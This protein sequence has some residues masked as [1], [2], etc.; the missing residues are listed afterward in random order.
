MHAEGRTGQGAAGL[1]WRRCARLAQAEDVTLAK[2]PRDQ[3]RPTHAELKEMSP[4]LHGK[5]E[6][7]AL[8]R[9]SPLTTGLN[10]AAV[11]A[12]VADERTKIESCAEHRTA[13]GSIVNPRTPPPQGLG[14]K[15]GP[16]RPGDTLWP[17]AE[18]GGAKAGR[19]AGTQQACSRRSRCGSSAACGATRQARPGSAG[20]ATALGGT[21]RVDAARRTFQSRMKMDVVGVVEFCCSGSSSAFSLERDSAFS[22]AQIRR[23]C[24][25]AADVLRAGGATG[26]SERDAHPPPLALIPPHVLDSSGVQKS[27]PTGGKYTASLAVLEFFP[28]RGLLVGGRRVPTARAHS[29]IRCASR[30]PRPT[31]ASTRADDR[32]TRSGHQR[33]TSRRDGG[34]V[35]TCRIRIQCIQNEAQ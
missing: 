31:R 27:L 28:G 17:S 5:S 6:P 16:G 10:Q 2:L 1:S 20:C 30:L 19:A 33:V 26:R 25:P 8:C 7:E 24:T 11:V 23:P 12:I 14:A 32:P 9:G 13:R 18:R 3:P 4:R 15:E 34:R 29:V 21:C 35:P 22:V